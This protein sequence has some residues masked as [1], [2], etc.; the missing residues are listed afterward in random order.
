MGIAPAPPWAT[1]YFAIHENNILPR[2]TSQVLFYRRFI[3]DIIGIWVCKED[4]E[5]NNAL[6]AR[7]TYDLQ[8]WYGLEWEFSPLSRSCQYMDLT[9]TLSG[10]T[11]HS[12]LFEK[13]QNLY[14]YL[15]PPTPHIPG[16][17]SRV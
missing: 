11:I 1:I 16:A 10:G 15:P 17:R 2:W 13:P 14:L 4:T 5:R 7:F 6:W 9:L 3:D 8:Q 12:T